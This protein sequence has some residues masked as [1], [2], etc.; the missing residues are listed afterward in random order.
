MSLNKPRPDYPIYPSTGYY[1]KRAEVFKRPKGRRGKKPKGKKLVPRG[2]AEDF[3]IIKAQDEAR[4]ARELALAQAQ[5]QAEFRQLQIADIEDKRVD[6]ERAN[7]A[8][9]DEL[10][11]RRDEQATN[12][13]TQREQLRLQDEAQRETQ[14]YRAEKIAIKQ[15]QGERRGQAEREII[16]QLR[17]LSEDNERRQGENREIFQQFLASQDRRGDLSVSNIQAQ[18]RTDLPVGGGI[19]GDERRSNRG[20]SVSLDLSVASNLS[21]LD[22]PDEE[23]FGGGHRTRGTEQRQK[24]KKFQGGATEAE[25]AAAGGIEGQTPQSHKAVVGSSG[26]KETQRRGD[27]AGKKTQDP[28]LKATGAFLEQL[29]ETTKISQEAKGKREK[30]G[31]GT[32]VIGGGD[33]WKDDPNI[34]PKKTA[35]GKVVKTKDPVVKAAGAFVKQLDETERIAKEAREERF[36]QKTQRDLDRAEQRAKPKLGLKLSSEEEIAEQLGQ[37]KKKKGRGE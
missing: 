28:L 4:K 25:L 16:G 34:T 17:N 12:D 9:Q 35:V 24:P 8:R 7:I 27:G 5:E 14:R 33:W 3:L 18:E 21:D 19:G 37:T 2:Q 30:R 10:Q 15:E 1:R 26:S 29:E 32:P 20:R 13:F 11:I 31:G 36:K 6:R 23:G 22:I